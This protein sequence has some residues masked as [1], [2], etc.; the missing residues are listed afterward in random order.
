MSPRRAL[1]FDM[2]ETLLADGADT[3]A[4]L[5]ATSAW[6]CARLM[7]L[8]QSNPRMSAEALAQAANTHAE[9]LWARSPAADYAQRIG[10]SAGEGLWGR[11][12]GD[13][14]GLQTLAAWAPGYQQGAWTGALA[15]LGVGAVPAHALAPEL[16]ARF[17]E[18][19][20][21]RHTLFPEVDEV[22]R[23]LQAQP[24]RYALGML[25]NG[26]PDVQKAK[27]AAAGL[28]PYFEAIVISGA[29][30]IGK[31]DPRI[32]AHTL[33]ALGF[34]DA[35]AADPTRAVMVGD[36]LPRDIVG[37]HR[38]SMRSIWIRR[39]AD[40]TP[41]PSSADETPDATITSLRELMA[42]L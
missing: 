17:R 13:D 18:E 4:A 14:P 42:V 32:F 33:A 11:F 10:I 20:L 3:W 39:D 19:R 5:L 16:A 24:T 8:G 31:P 36:S 34:V 9:S 40:E 30:G 38:S 26:A 1:I 28:E 6:A 21:A 7:Q 29:V 27:I 37:A 23:A 12:T 35:A 2:D 41:T 25:T 15:G 22:L